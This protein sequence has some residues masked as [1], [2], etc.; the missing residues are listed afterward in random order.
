MAG[1][2]NNKIVIRDKRGPVRILDLEENKVYSFGYKHSRRPGSEGTIEGIFDIIRNHAAV[3]LPNGNIVLQMERGTL[4]HSWDCRSTYSL[5]VLDL[6]KGDTYTLESFPV[7]TSHWRP[8]SMDLRP[9]N[10]GLFVEVGE[11]FIRIWD[12]KDK[13]NKVVFSLEEATIENFFPNNYIVARNTEGSIQIWNINTEKCV[14]LFNDVSS[15]INITLEGYA[16][17]TGDSG[18]IKIWNI[19]KGELIGHY[20]NEDIVG[21]S[22]EYIV[23]RGADGVLR[24]RDIGMVED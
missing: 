6:E 23:S 7:D 1:L 5:E 3:I 22:G 11:K 20:L 12:S 18:D 24:I 17:C 19:N 21:A 2:P 9:I 10:D 4:G 16:V 13:N 14:A 8:S 15:V